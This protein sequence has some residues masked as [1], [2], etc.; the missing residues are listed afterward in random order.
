MKLLQNV[1]KGVQDEK[2]VALVQKT[3]LK[4]KKK[5]NEEYTSLQFVLI[6]DLESTSPILFAK[7]AEMLLSKHFSL[8]LATRKKSLADRALSRRNVTNLS[9]C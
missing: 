3:P 1:D 7:K 6:C 5:E 4:A 2:K 9:A 8:G